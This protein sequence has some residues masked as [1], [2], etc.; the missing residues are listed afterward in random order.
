MRYF[1]VN[2]KICFVGTE[3]TPSVGSTFIGGHVNTVVGLCRGLTD[4]GWEVHIVT[5][6][7]RFMKTAKFSFPWAEFHLIHA[8]SMYNSIGY[9]FDYMMKAIKTVRDLHEKEN[10]AL[11]H[12]HSGYF[13]SSI[14]PAMAGKSLNIPALF[15]LYCPASLLPRK[16]PKESYAIKTLSYGLDKVIA[17]TAN[18]K[19]SLI[20]C[21]VKA[22][23]IEVI[24]SCF[25]QKAFNS[26][27]STFGMNEKNLKDSKTLMVLFVG[28]ADKTKGLDIFLDA[29][30]SILRNNP[31]VK[32]VVTLHESVTCL[33][34]VRSVASKMLG[35]S[36]EVLGV[37]R[38]MAQLMSSADMVVAPFRSTEGISDIPIVV[39]E[40]MALGKPVIASNL[41]G[42]KEA[43]R[44]GE[45]GLI[46]DI[47]DSG[48]IVNA[49]TILLENPVLRDEIGNQAILC[50]KRFSHSEISRQ[51]S[52]LY[53][54]IVE[55]A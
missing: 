48:E 11:V 54:R 45:N 23:R 43:I 8:S 3:I 53:L 35:S 55:T 40:A 12:A 31:D 4:L 25:D 27:V 38:N 17:V 39:L 20:K 14:I 28:N 26:T 52:N 34:R 6:P 22:E 37:V 7:S 16:L 5:T 47:K 49:V 33:Q 24:P 46:V 36:V 44:D 15:S 21:G 32:F 30:K 41:E 10:L 19:E 1:T 13:G 29:G 18:V 42:I 50:A 9:Y 51:L 2:H